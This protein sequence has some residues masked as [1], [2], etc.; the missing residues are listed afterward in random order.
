MAYDHNVDEV[1]WSFNSVYKATLALNAVFVDILF[2]SG[3]CGA[4]RTFSIVVKL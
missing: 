2:S 4:G 3:E 1:V